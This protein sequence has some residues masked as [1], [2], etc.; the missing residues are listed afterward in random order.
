MSSHNLSKIP[1]ALPVR[2]KTTNPFQTGVSKTSQNTRGSVTAPREASRQR[3]ASSAAWQAQALRQ[4]SSGP[5]RHRL[6]DQRTEGGWRGAPAAPEPSAGAASPRAPAR[7]PVLT[8]APPPPP[9]TG[10]RKWRPVHPP[11]W[12]LARGSRSLM[13]PAHTCAVAAFQA[14]VGLIA[15]AAAL[16]VAWSSPPRVRRRGRSGPVWL[17]WTPPRESACLAERTGGSATRRRPQLPEEARRGLAVAS[18]CGQ[19]W[20]RTNPWRCSRSPGSGRRSRRTRCTGGA[21]R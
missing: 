16:R 21:T 13:T 11:R 14:G 10:G 15:A 5:A 20:P 7:Q 3:P 6:R 12:R 2:G 8:S 17:S 19:P 18:A 4:P 9:L 1:I